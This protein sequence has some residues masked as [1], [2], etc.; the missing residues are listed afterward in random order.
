M[1]TMPGTADLRHVPPGVRWLA[2]ALLVAGLAAGQPG[3]QAAAYPLPAG[4]V[5]GAVT[6]L[7]LRYEDTLAA[8]ARSHGLGYTEL[9]IANPEVDPWLPGEGTRIELPTAYVLPDAPR[10]GLVINVAEYRAY[11]YPR[12]WDVV[13]TF[14]VGVGR[15]EY[16]TPEME[17]RVVTRIEN[18]SW[19]PTPEARREHAEMGD[20][21][22]PVG[23]PGPDNP[24]GSMA[25]QLEAPGYFIHGTNKPFG[26]GQ[27]VSHGCIRLYDEHIQTLVELM[28]NGTPVRI[29]NQPFKVGLKDGELWAEAHG[30]LY[31][32]RSSDRLEKLVAD[33]AERH[34]LMVAWSKVG[35]MTVRLTGVPVN[36]T[37]GTPPA[38]AAH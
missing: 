16:Q 32:A 36:L 33:A 14:P 20:V 7:T 5:V 21:L 28:P 6:P 37:Q 12:D 22:P 26:V 34:N 38:T 23:P 17:T 2:M 27:M 9:L 29:V 19:T 25:L 31:G 10:Q 1:T 4:D 13:I 30:Q 18:P 11:F 15:A 8:I 3:A 35:E 24:L